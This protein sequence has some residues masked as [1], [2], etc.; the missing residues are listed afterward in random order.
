MTAVACQSALRALDPARWGLRPIRG[1]WETTSA[2]LGVVRI[3]RLGWPHAQSVSEPGDPQPTDAL[4][5]LARLQGEVWGMPPSEWVPANLL[6]VLP[7]TGGSVLAAYRATAGWTPAGWLGFAIAAGSRTGVAVSHMLGVREEARGDHDLG[8]LLK[9]VQAHAAVEAGH[10][11][12]TWTF[13][14]LRGANARLNIEKLGATVSTLTL[15]KYGPLRSALYGDV[16]SDRFTAEW[17][18]LSPRTSA[19]LAAVFAGDHRGPDRIASEGAPLATAAD[20]EGLA[21]AAPPAVRYAIPADVDRLHRDDPV[22]ANGWRTAMRG[23]LSPLLTVARAEPGARN[24]D[25]AEVVVHRRVGRYRVTGFVSAID[26]AGGRRNEYLLT[27]RD[28]A[29]DDRDGDAA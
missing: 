12:M 22:L 3:A 29:A 27:R 16:P 7:D 21:R 15:D 25:P 19:R 14:P 9:V 10:H 2:A 17:D 8:W 13:D 20:A 23:A 24:H 5:F 1:G 18:L 28:A 11:A 4:A 26:A 6:A